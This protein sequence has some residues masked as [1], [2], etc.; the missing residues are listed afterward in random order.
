MRVAG[1]FDSQALRAHWNWVVPD[2]HVPLL[3]SIFGDWV[4]CAEDGGHWA[5]SILD[6]SYFK[7]A[8]D[9]EDFD[10]KKRSFEWLSENFIAEWQ[11][12]SDRAGV[13]PGA[14]E[15]IGW[16]IPPILGGEFCVENMKIF[17]MNSWQSIMGQVL[18][19][20][21]ERSSSGAAESEG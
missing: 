1:E 17:P 8:E 13:I 10:T 6:G 20:F 9:C 2:H 18:R 12:I 11:E 3:I 5:L 15:C 16:K 14:N 19:Q 7:V 4:F 21:A